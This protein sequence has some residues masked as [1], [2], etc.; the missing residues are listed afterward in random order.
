MFV[1]L[2]YSRVLIS[3]LYGRC[4]S[5]NKSHIT[6]V[7]AARHRVSRFADACDLNRW[8]IRAP[9]IRRRLLKRS[10]IQGRR[11]ELPINS[12]RIARCSLSEKPS[13]VTCIFV[14]LTMHYRLRDRERFLNNPVLSRKRHEVSADSRGRTE[15]GIPCESFWFLHHAL[16]V[17][18]S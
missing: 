5:A 8:D 10:A 12:R 14:L 6:T 11:F 2:R 7:A 16:H 9:E 3:I 18:S 17:L 4:Q 13:F 15:L 1:I